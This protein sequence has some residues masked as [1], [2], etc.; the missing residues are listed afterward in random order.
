MDV[1]ATANDEYHQMLMYDL[2][3]AKRPNKKRPKEYTRPYMKFPEFQGSDRFCLGMDYY[4]EM[5]I[6]A[7]GNV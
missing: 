4:P 3:F 5:K 6:L 2:R 7:T 1:L